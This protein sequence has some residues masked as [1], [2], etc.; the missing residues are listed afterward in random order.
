MNKIKKKKI[1]IFLI[2]FVMLYILIYL[3]PRITGAL[4]QT[5]IAKYENLKVEDKIIGY[6]VR[7]EKVYSAARSG[8]INKYI[9]EGELIKKGTSVLEITGENTDEIDP[10]YEKIISELGSNMICDSS[11]KSRAEGIVSYYTDGCENLFTPEK[12]QKMTFESVKSK[13]VNTVVSLDRKTAVKG[14]P[15][16]KIIDRSCWYFLCWIDTSNAKKYI[17]GKT[18]T[19]AFGKDNIFADVYKTIDQGEYTLII[20]KTNRYYEN[21]DKSRFAGVSLIT[22]DESGLIVENSSITT[23]NKQKGVYRKNKVGEYIFTPIKIITTDGKKSVV[24]KSYF[25]DSDGKLL[26]TINN[27][28]E[29]LKNPKRQ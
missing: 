22:S 18:I 9:K 23:E 25:Y 13:I 7:D 3:V 27:Y 6:F 20:L 15:I 4:T 1:I 17:V 29:V 8:K 11:Y 24:Q 26:N 14:E 2:A 28:D 19:I 12:M 10:K 16:F 5:Y 21:F